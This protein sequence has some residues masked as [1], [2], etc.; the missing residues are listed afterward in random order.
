MEI[1]ICSAVFVGY[2]FC[3]AFLSVDVV[4]WMLFFTR[5]PIHAG[6]AWH[7]TLIILIC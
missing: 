4:K 2:G 3:E 5:F 7:R 1:I 6:N